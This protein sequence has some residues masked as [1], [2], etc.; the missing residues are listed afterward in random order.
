MSPQGKLLRYFIWEALQIKG[1]KISEKNYTDYINKQYKIGLS[2]IKSDMPQIFTSF[3]NFLSMLSSSHPSQINNLPYVAAFGYMQGILIHE[4]NNG[5]KNTKRNVGLTSSM[6]MIGI[7]L[8]DHF[9]DETSSREKIFKSVNY[10]FLTNIMNP[11][12]KIS[13]DNIILSNDN[14]NLILWIIVAFSMLC[15][16]LY[17]ESRNSKAWVQLSESILQLFY[18]EK[19]S[20]DICNNNTDLSYSE[21]LNIIKCK[22]VMPTFAIYLL[23]ELANS[24]SSR[25][26]QGKIKDICNIIG[27]IVGL[28]DDLADIIID[29]ESGVPNIITLKFQRKNIYRIKN[30][31]L[32]DDIVCEVIFS[33]VDNL[34]TLLE[35][36]EKELKSLPISIST[37]YKIMEFVKMN[38][39]SWIG[40]WLCDSTKESN[41][42]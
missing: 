31:F 1:F 27:N 38:V 17:H 25:K 39:T 5:S 3:D 29:L 12:I 24:T 8:F 9:I 33:T 41:S 6:F 7:H 32:Y 35:A 23:S 16:N 40:E 26:N 22:S 21:I 13:C 2:I 18:A 34:L 11:S 10:D 14:K 19:L 28:S 15:K 36:L 4:L 42:R 30:N 20:C 37:N